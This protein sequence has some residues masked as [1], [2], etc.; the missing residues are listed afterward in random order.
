MITCFSELDFLKISRL[1][2]RIKPQYF[3][4][5][6]QPAL[7]L[8]LAGRSVTMLRH[9]L[10]IFPIRLA[11]QRYGNCGSRPDSAWYV[12]FRHIFPAKKLQNYG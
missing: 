12:E 3:R 10:R 2:Y 4:A 5:D 9:P 8:S 7:E 11:D 6:L 1:N